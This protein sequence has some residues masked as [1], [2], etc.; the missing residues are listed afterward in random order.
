MEGLL[1]DSVV[2]EAFGNFACCL[3][4]S[5][6][7]SKLSLET[8]LMLLDP[9]VAE[10]GAMSLQKLSTRECLTHSTKLV[11]SSAVVRSLVTTVLGAKQS[12]CGGCDDEG[13]E[14]D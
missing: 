11:A 3:K 14:E 4:R 5:V 8:E 2:D 6:A 13:K 10:A 12:S 7:L 1:F 9:A